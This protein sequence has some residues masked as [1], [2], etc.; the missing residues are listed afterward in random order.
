MRDWAAFVRNH[1]SLPQLVPEREAR[2]VRELAA[3][4]EDFYR[5]ALARGASETE[6]DAH[7]RAQI[8]DWSRMARDVSQAD[9]RHARPRLERLTNHIEHLAAQP[10]RRSG[11]LQILAQIL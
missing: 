6:A 5:D 3:Q 4:L 7:A 2:I 11:P 9:H 8:G 10:R 1:L